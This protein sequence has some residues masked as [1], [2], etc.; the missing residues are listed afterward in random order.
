MK[1]FSLNIEDCIGWLANQA[2]RIAVWWTHPCRLAIAAGIDPGQVAQAPAQ[3]EAHEPHHVAEPDLV[4]KGLAHDSV[5]LLGSMVIAISS[6]APAYALTATLGPTV[7]EVGA[8]MPA[9]FLIGFVPMLLVAYAYRGLNQVA[10]DAGTSFT[11]TVKA[12]GPHVG[13]L[14]GW[15]LVIAT[16]IVLSN[17]AGVAVT[18]FYL[19][20]AEVTGDAD[21]ATWGDGRV[22]NVATC[23]AFVAIATFVAYRGMTATKGVM[24][25]LVSIQLVALALFVGFA[26][27]KATGGD[28][29]TSIDFEWSWLSP[30]SVTTFSAL[31]TGLS[32]SIFMYW[33]WDAALSANEE[34]SGSERTPGIAALL[35]LL[36]LGGT[37]VL[38]GVAALMFA[39]TGEQGVGLGNED[40]AD[41]V[42]AA[43]A[44]PVL[45]GTLSL[46][47]F[48]AV[49]A[50]SAS[51]L[52]T[53]FIPAARTILAMSVY[54]A[55]PERL[56]TMHPVHRIPGHA[57]LVSGVGT[58]AF[59]TL[60]TFVSEDVLVDTI[61]SLGLMICFY[62][63][64]TAFAAAWYF[65]RELGSFKALILK[66]VAPVLGGLVLTAV[67]VKLVIDTVDPEYGSGGSVL[68]LGTVFVLGVG[69]LLLGV[70]LMFAWQARA[71]AFFRGETLKHDTP[72]LVVEEGGDAGGGETEPPQR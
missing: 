57:T 13:W 36:I 20:L 59:Y 28:A 65:R 11:W 14:C 3:I 38:V 52:Q 61:L 44:D 58:A 40:T 12:F 1:A 34:T 22:A 15:G 35:S 53:T 29:T 18:F 42:F 56:G 24:Y 9:I 30:F 70:V 17:L 10:P 32:L 4:D 21:I 7:T 54:K 41:N 19:F 48:L 67:F 64:L 47:L 37:Y 5:G 71:G 60:M 8:Q 68:G 43:L 39:G 72:T 50:S 16:I 27:A 49:L 63:G 55:L 69:L 66:G 62:Y 31:A 51:S 26:L 2:I 46:L 6:V 33:G 25:V 23:L 45:G